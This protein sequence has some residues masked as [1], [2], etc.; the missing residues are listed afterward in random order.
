MK[1]LLLL[2]LLLNVVGLS[3]A[4]GHSVPLTWTQSVTPG[5]TANKI[6]RGTTLGGPYTVLFSSTS[7]ITAFTDATVT[8]GVTYYYVVTAV[9]ATCNAQES[10]FSNEAKAVVPG[11]Q[12]APPGSLTVT[13]V[14]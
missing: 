3:Y 10:A 4:A 8:G 6:Y 7:P 9:C 14:Q 11:D 12:P 5:I 1:K 2:F 13:G